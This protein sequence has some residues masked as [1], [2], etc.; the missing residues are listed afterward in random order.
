MDIGVVSTWCLLWI[1]Q[2]WNS[3]TYVFVWT[4][5]F[6][7]LEY[8][9]GSEIVGFYV[10]LTIKLFKK[11][12]YLFMRERKGVRTSRGRAKGEGKREYQVGSPLS[13]DPNGGLDLMT[14]RSCPEPKS[15]VRCSASWATRRPITIYFMQGCKDNSANSAG[16]TGYSYAKNKFPSTAH[17]IYK[18]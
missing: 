7:Y 14:L 2:L 8:I 1:M 9:P 12:M 17:P 6:S 5:V 15:R 10:N 3:G 11:N 16:T 4:R 13:T 18:I